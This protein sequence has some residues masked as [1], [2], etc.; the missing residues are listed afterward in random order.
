[1][2][3]LRRSTSK[4]RLVRKLG[5]ICYPDSVTGGAVL[6]V[7]E[8][9]CVSPLSFAC[10]FCWVS[11]RFFFWVSVEFYGQ[12]VGSEVSRYGAGHNKRPLPSGHL[13]AVYGDDDRALGRVC[14]TARRLPS[15]TQS[16]GKSNG[17]AVVDS[18]H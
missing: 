9:A 7:C 17:S 6:G 8:C 10:F 12:L 13:G 4:S 18:Y 15:P 3:Q 11:P 1:M 16:M 2:S 14:P 5:K